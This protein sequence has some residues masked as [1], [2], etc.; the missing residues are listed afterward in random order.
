[1]RLLDISG[2]TYGLWT[3]I[4]RAPSANGCTRWLCQCACGTRSEVY[5]AFLVDGR[6]RSCGCQKP[7]ISRA[8]ATTHGGTTLKEYRVWCWMKDRC[9]NPENPKYSNY[10]GR[11][12]TV[13]E[14]WGDFPSFLE[15]MGKRPSPEHTIERIN[16]NGNYEPGNC[17]WATRLEQANNKRNNRGITFQGITMNL[18]QW[19]RQTGI[20][21][22]VISQRLGKLGWTVEDA[23]TVPTRHCDRKT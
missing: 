1:M 13:C 7:A 10:G 20:G 9:S 2:K 3:V 5:A 22:D 23:L 16:N 18:S 14:R 11:G 17:R 12:I 6:S 19:A 4:E 21:V 8:L 15:D